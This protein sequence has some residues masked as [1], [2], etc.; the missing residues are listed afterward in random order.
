MFVNQSHLVEKMNI[1]AM[2]LM[3]TY[4]YAFTSE[5]EFIEFDVDLEKKTV[6]MA[7]VKNIDQFRGD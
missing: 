5:G 4:I 7:A 3:N 1:I 2:N 6:K